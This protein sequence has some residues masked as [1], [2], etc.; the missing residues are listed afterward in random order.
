MRIKEANA[1]YTGG[2]IYLFYGKVYTGY[3]F[4]TDDHGWTLIL[5]AD[6]S[7]LDESTFPEWQEKHLV[8]ELCGSE[9]ALFGFTL[10]EWIRGLDETSE[11]RG[12]MASSEIDAYEHEW[13]E[14]YIEFLP[15]EATHPKK[16]YTAYVCVHGYYITDVEASSIEEACEIAECKFEEDADLGDITDIDMGVVTE[17]TDEDGEIHYT[18]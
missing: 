14:S 2:G 15:R 6:P 16:K 11:E 3:Y 9:C 4:L 7:D 1:V 10:L 17:L 5:D 13:L 18:F 8:K 12:G